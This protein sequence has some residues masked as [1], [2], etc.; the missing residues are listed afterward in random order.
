MKRMMP[1]ICRMANDLVFPAFLARGAGHS[2]RVDGTRRDYDV[3]KVV[4]D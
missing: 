4:Q 1:H 3:D 2:L